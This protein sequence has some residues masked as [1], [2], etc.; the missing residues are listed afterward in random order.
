[1]V[2][3]DKVVLLPLPVAEGAFRGQSFQ[4]SA[5][6]RRGA[7]PAFRS[8]A[9]KEHPARA[10]LDAR[11]DQQREASGPEVFP[12]RASRSARR[13]CAGNT[14]E[15]LRGAYRIQDVD[16]ETREARAFAYAHGTRRP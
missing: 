1:M 2:A 11:D 6:L 7:C 13:Q 14:R 3:D 10:A 5:D 9:G 4:E 15:F 12:V 8:V 16:P